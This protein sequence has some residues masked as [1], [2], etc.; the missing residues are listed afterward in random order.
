MFLSVI[1]IIAVAG[2]IGEGE[3]RAIE[4]ITT[5]GPLYL[6]ILSFLIIFILIFSI[7]YKVLDRFFDALKVLESAVKKLSDRD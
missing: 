7:L 5:Q 4:S 1:P 2:M 6:A 3:G